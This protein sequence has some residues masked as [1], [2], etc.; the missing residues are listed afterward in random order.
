MSA[1]SRVADPTACARL[2]RLA[3]RAIAVAALAGAAQ[4]AQQVVDVELQPLAASVARVA[5]ALEL[6][7]APLPAGEREALE[8][9]AGAADPRDGVASIQEILDRHC[10]AFVHI[11]PESR[12]KVSEGPA[13]KKLVQHGW[14][15]F[16]VKVH[17]QG[18]VT[19]P[20]D[21]TSPQAEPPGVISNNVP[22]PGPGITPAQLQQRF[23]DVASFEQQPLR[24]GLSGLALEYRI[25][26]LHSRDAG[27]REATLV[28]GVGRGTLDLGYRSE[29]PVLF[30]CAPA[31][32]L[33][34]EVLDE[35]GAPTIASFIVR[36]ETGLVCPAQ[37]RR[38]PP[39]FFFQPQVYRGNGESLWLAPGTYEFVYGRGP[40]YLEGRRT[41]QVSVGERREESFRLERWIHPAELGW[42]SGDH[43]IH[44]AGCEHYDSPTKG[45]GPA[46]MFRHILGEDLN[47][48]CV[49]T[50][51]PCWN[52]Q[53]SFFEG[54][55]HELSQER[56]LM[57]Y[58]VEVSGFP[59]SHAGHLALLRLRE[60]DY[61]GT[62]SIDEWPSWNLPILHWAKEQGAVVG[63]CHSGTGLLVPGNRLPNY[64]VPP[65][66]S[67]GANEYIVDVVHG[68]VDF[69]AMCNTPIIFELNL[70]YHTLNCG[71]RTRI[72]GET[73]FPC[74]YD[75]KVG[76]GRSYV[77]LDKQEGRRLDFDAWVEGLRDG[78]TYVSDGKSHIIDFEVDGV[79]VGKPGSGDVVSELAL[80]APRTVTVTARVAALLG[81]E[82]DRAVRE[83][84]LHNKPY[85]SIERVRLGDSRKVPVELVVNGRSVA[86]Q[87]LLA[88]GS[89]HD[90]RF[91][92]PIERS[93]WVALRVFASS[94]T[95][96]VFVVVG[97]APVRPS[98]RSAQ[99]CLDGIDASWRQRAPA[100]RESEL[101]AAE[102]AFE[103]ARRYY[104]Q[105][106]T[107]SVGD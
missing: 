90:V 100:I 8:E 64:A 86:R 42:W 27:L 96:P 11:N 89:L 36:D 71:F 88:D 78:R 63:Y 35:N 72:S 69:I 5:E 41:V 44:A 70:W 107:E 59:S 99:W 37:M 76:L 102:A 67:I 105:V 51:G 1:T 98:R 68:A 32:E 15:T 54:K 26:H 17:N 60:D 55:V 38:V 16:L 3:R 7:G 61:P 75:D 66:D 84:P 93:S 82:P 80:D 45:V 104:R 95:N 18:R 23:L 97:G 47:V 103:E 13:P 9:A 20:L 24:A 50:W 48:G 46:E 43:H 87:D 85:W 91:E 10:L 53:K 14:R 62:T 30:E 31:V 12:V 94:H 6:L 33:K 34:L 56:H 101:P 79:A 81:L 57:R 73:D 77:R 52:F 19:A 2:W 40:E 39:D 49:L 21:L 29:L 106:L 74:I 25:V 65:F 83:R 28:F 92:A 58:D 4:A 22:E